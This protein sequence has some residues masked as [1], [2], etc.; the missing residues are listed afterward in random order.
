MPYDLKSEYFEWM[1]KLVCNDKYSNGL[2]YRKLLYHLY[3]TEF[4][5]ILEK[6]SN[7]ACDGIDFR[8]RFGYENKIPRADIERYLDIDPCNLLEMMISLSYKVE[9]TIM[10]DSDYGD[11]TGQWFWNMIVNLE[12]GHMFDSQF[13]TNYVENVVTRLLN[14]TYE[15][16]GKGGLFTV[17]NPR[18]DMRSV[19][20]WYQTMWYFDDNYDFSIK[21]IAGATV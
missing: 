4:I 11:R 3:N 8:Y 7:R 16:N 19:E 12:L 2:S 9:E 1:Y 5:Y 13:D 10:D 18:Y 15:S 20:I 14:R 21:D 6:D 17:N